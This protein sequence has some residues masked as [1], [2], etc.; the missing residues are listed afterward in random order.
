MRHFFCSQKK[1]TF[2]TNLTHAYFKVVTD[3]KGVDNYGSKGIQSSGEKISP[4]SGTV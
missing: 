3:W 4:E 1:Q 2:F